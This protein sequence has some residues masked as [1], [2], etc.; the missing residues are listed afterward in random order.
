MKRLISALC[1]IFLLFVLAFDVSAHEVPD[2]TRIGSITFTLMQDAE[3]LQGGS[4]TMYRVGDV[5]EDDGNYYFALVEELVETGI[6][7]DDMADTSLAKELAQ[8]AKDAQ[9]TCLTANVQDGKAA[10]SDVPNGL[11]VVLQYEED[12]CEGFLPIN[13]FLI[14]M[15]MYTDGGYAYDISCKPKVSLVPV[16][17]QPEPDPV[18]PPTGQE[19]LPIPLMVVSGIV[20]FIL[21]WYPGFRRRKVSDEG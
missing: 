6:R 16:P 9:L 13:A 12:A 2:L 8:A 19:A 11:Y 21:G 10:F 18:L 1:A 15:P 14:S 20:L 3:P 7:L 5:L 4:L 17:D